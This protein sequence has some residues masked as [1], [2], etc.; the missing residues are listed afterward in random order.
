MNN[1]DLIP[2]DYSR[3]MVIKRH[4]R[5]FLCLFPALVL[6]LFSSKFWLNSLIKGEQQAAATL[7]T[8]AA[9]IGNQKAQID[10]LNQT[11][12]DLQKRLDLFRA[13]RGGPAVEQLFVVIDRA[14]NQNVWLTTL[15]FLRSGMKPATNKKEVNTGYFI[16]V[17]KGSQALKKEE[18]QNLEHM[19]LNGQAKTFADLA[20]FI[21]DFAN[22]PDIVDVKVQQTRLHESGATKSVEFSLIVV[23]GKEAANQ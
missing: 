12:D 13:L 7:Q 23:L 9:A 15:E 5:L 2:A 22:Q 3:F 21:K 19:K 6:L 1:V 17:P 10:R 14:I 4:V 16:V 20:E 8:N 11:R 18:W